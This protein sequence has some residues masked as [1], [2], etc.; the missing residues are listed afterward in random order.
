MTNLHIVI[1]GRPIPQGSKRAFVHGGRAIMREASGDALAT[2]RGDIARE[3]RAMLDDSD[4]YTGAV[5]V[6]LEFRF[7][8]PRSHY[9]TGRNAHLLRD[10]APSDPT[11]PPDIDKTIRAVLDALTH[12]GAFRDDAQVVSLVARKFYIPATSQPST[13]ITIRPITQLGARA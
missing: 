3:A 13:T 2:Y 11:K 1:P 4:P 7:A 10:N 6:G 8:R 9:R 5:H 12:A